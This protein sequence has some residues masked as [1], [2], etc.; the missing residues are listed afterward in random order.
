MMA[1]GPFRTVS[2]LGGMHF[3]R[4]SCKQ[5]SESLRQQSEW[6]VGESNAPCVYEK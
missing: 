5:T 3:V 2:C 6:R 4:F 1:K